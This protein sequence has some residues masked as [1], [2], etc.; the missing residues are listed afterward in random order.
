MLFPHN[1]DLH[2]LYFSVKM[3][4]VNFTQVDEL[5]DRYKIT[6]A[7]MSEDI[8]SGDITLN[9]CSVCPRTFVKLHYLKHHMLRTHKSKKH[10][11]SYPK[12]VFLCIIIL[13]KY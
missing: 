9:S 12:F 3:C 6:S 5:D 4:D 7:V 8:K 1:I 13:L 11:H 10:E 2:V